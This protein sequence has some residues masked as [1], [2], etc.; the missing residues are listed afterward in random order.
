MAAPPNLGQGLAAP[1]QALSTPKKPVTKAPTKTLPSGT[2]ALNALTG[3]RSGTPGMVD[4]PPIDIQGLRTMLVKAGYNIPTKGSAAGALMKAALR[5]YLQPTA[6]HPVAQR[7]LTL[8][9]ASKPGQPIASGLRNPTQFNQQHGLLKGGKVNPP[10]RPTS[11]GVD[12]QF[13]PNGNSLPEQPVADDGSGQTIDLRALAGLTTV[14]NGLGTAVPLIPTSLADKLA[15]LAHDTQI[16]DLGIQAQRQ[17]ADAGQSL[18]DINHWYNQVAG[19]RSSAATQDHSISQAGQQSVQDAVAG[20]VASLGG[21]ANQGSGQV[22]AAGAEQAGLLAALGSNEDQYNADLKPLLAG[23]SAGALTRQ[24]ATNTKSAKDI[25]QQILDQQ[26][27][28]G[29]DKS[30]ALLQI[31]GENATRRA[32]NNQLDQNRFQDNLAVQQAQEAAMLNG[33]KVLSGTKPP[34]P[35]K[36][37]FHASSTTDRVGFTK[38]VLSQIVPGGQ[39]PKGMTRSKAISIAQRLAHIYFPNGG[40]PNGTGLI[41]SIVNQAG[42]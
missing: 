11:T 14:A 31:L 32:S 35:P 2:G 24:Q 21:S 38:D 15:G 33:Y 28:R 36:G 27:Q 17:G 22:G 19:A 23:E 16:H 39:L 1:G 20:I 12:R 7:L 30:N 8:I 13:D 4:A 10:T 41:A 18:E 34:A 25:Q 9:G 5:D 6:S 3:G 26:G 37:S 29:Q 40:I 42:L